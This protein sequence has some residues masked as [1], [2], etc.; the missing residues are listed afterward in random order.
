MKETDT[1]N[2]KD[3]SVIGAGSVA[4]AGVGWKVKKYIPVKTLPKKIGLGLGAGVLLGG[5]AAKKIQKKDEPMEKVVS[6]VVG[7]QVG[8]IIMPIPGVGA[9]IGNKISKKLYEKVAKAIE[10]VQDSAENVTMVGAGATAVVK[11]K[12]FLKPY[13]VENVPK[14]KGLKWVVETPHE[15]YRPHPFTMGGDVVTLDELK[16]SK[17]TSK[18]LVGILGGT[19][20]FNKKLWKEDLSKYTTGKVRANFTEIKDLE[21]QWN[22]YKQHKGS[23]KLPK[24]VRAD[25]IKSEA[26]LTKLFP[27]GY[28]GKRRLAYAGQGLVIGDTPKHIERQKQVFKKD[29]RHVRDLIGDKNYV[30]QE[31]IDLPK[32]KGEYRVTTAGG[33][34]MSVLP[35][36]ASGEIN[37]T[38]SAKYRKKGA[39][40][41]DEIAR[42]SE[43]F[44]KK[45]LKI[46]KEGI[47]TLDVWKD[48]S[49]KLLLNES[50]AAGGANLRSGISGDAVRS[51]NYYTKGRVPIS[52][53]ARRKA[54]IIGGGAALIALGVGTKK[55]L[56]KKGGLDRV[57]FIIP[58]LKSKFIRYGT[59]A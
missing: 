10:T 37:Y 28:V 30:F 36:K 56:E 9:A 35:R 53:L 58:S 23:G 2:F 4:G 45:D 22:F 52:Y 43:E 6:E 8:Q 1:T 39:K 34:V 21:D 42:F 48:R 33:K 47:H 12:K 26:Q 16:K 27:K 15:K 57:G 18:D 17:K 40:K 7:T 13:N 44:V 49:G 11:G 59:T 25:Q 32:F 19:K 3:V 41:L 38:S 50:N 29:I 31:K 55:M 24:T 5:I 46:N 51:K 20:L 54:G 14:S